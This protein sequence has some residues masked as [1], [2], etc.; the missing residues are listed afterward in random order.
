M[1][2]ETSTE[3]SDER[4]ARIL[5]VFRAISEDEQR[6]AQICRDVHDACASGRTCLVLTQRTERIDAIAVELAALGD[7]ALVLKP[8]PPDSPT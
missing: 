3:V 4:G 5:Q 1:V 2:H 6:T 7:T 8:P